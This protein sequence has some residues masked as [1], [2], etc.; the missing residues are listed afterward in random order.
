M[1]FVMLFAVDRKRV[2]C[3]SIFFSEGGKKSEG[4]RYFI[5]LVIKVLVYH[6]FYCSFVPV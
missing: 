6:S 2:L 3:Y 1:T 4:A 5:Q